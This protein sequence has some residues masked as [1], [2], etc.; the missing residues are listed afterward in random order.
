MLGRTPLWI[1]L[2]VRVMDRKIVT[3]EDVIVMT[4]A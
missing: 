3:S 4:A 2:S 1:R